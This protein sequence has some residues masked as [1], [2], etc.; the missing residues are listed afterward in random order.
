[1]IYHIQN[2]MRSTQLCSAD[3]KAWH[4]VGTD[5]THVTMRKWLTLPL[6]NATFAKITIH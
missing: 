1:M 2:A 6:Y 5:T 4:C 3:N